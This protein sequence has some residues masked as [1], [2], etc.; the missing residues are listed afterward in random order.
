MSST[1]ALAPDKVEEESER[2]TSPAVDTD[3]ADEDVDVEMDSGRKDRS[4]S[5]SK[6]VC[7]WECK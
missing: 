6:S 3:D 2:S 4:W 7:E 1:A 5:H